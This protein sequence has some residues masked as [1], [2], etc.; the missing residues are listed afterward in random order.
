MIFASNTNR[1]S[2]LITAV[3]ALLLLA[4]AL[5][6]PTAASAQTAPASYP[7]CPTITGEGAVTQWT[8]WTAIAAVNHLEYGITAA[9]I[10]SFASIFEY[11][12]LGPSPWPGTYNLYSGIYLPLGKYVSAQFRVPVSTDFSTLQGQ[13]SIDTAHFSAPVSMTI[14][15]LCGDFGQM[16]AST[17]IANCS[18][19]SANAGQF[20]AWQGA[21]S[22]QACVLTPGFVYYLNVINADISQLPSTGIAV[23]TANSACNAAGCLDPIVNGPGNWGV[24]DDIFYSPFEQ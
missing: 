17:I 5:S 4:A 11:P 15:T 7:G 12:G 18:V 16:S 19:N 21:A 9:D 13:Y 1:A 10:T 8:Q 3:H 24:A 6:T 20:L 14:S 23:S 22:P 2:C